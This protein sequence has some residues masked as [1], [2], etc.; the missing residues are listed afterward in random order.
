MGAGRIGQECLQERLGLLKSTCRKVQD[1]SE[2]YVEVGGIG[3]MCLQEQVGLVKG[4]CGSGRDWL[5]VSV[6]G[7]DQT[8]CWWAW[9]EKC[10]QLT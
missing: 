2:V 9:G 5:R 3:Q 1:W 4:V 10:K 6:S 7:T 8:F